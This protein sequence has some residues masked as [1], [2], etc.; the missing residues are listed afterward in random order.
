MLERKMKEKTHSLCFFTCLSPLKRNPQIASKLPYFS[1]RSLTPSL[2]LQCLESPGYSGCLHFLIS[3]RPPLTAIR[4]PPHPQP[5]TGLLAKDSSWHLRNGLCCFI[6]SISLC[7]YSPFYHQ[8]N[9][10]Q[11]QVGSCEFCA[12]MLPGVPGTQRSHGI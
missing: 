6:P 9:L 11:M 8:R 10:S 7:S 2:Y 12:E 4:T 5:E 1:H 3:Y